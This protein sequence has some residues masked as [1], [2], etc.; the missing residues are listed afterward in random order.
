MLCVPR[1]WAASPCVIERMTVIL[2]A[3]WA[4]FGSVS[5][6]DSPSILVGDR[7]QLA[8]VFD[9]GE[10]LGV[11]RFLV[12]HAAG[13]EDVDDRLGLGRDRRVVLQLGPGL[14]AGRSR[15]G[16][17]RS[18]TA[19]TVRNPRRLNPRRG[20]AICHRSSPATG[21]GGPLSSATYLRTHDTAFGP[22]VDS[23]KPGGMSA[24]LT[25]AALGPALFQ[26][27]RTG[28]GF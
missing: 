2:S 15:P 7:R 13:Q 27:H 22:K 8:A 11:E 4:V 6:N 9:R 5:Q 25:R 20:V 24:G 16:S 19:P 23:L 10:R 18:P 12:G 28:N 21:F 14:A 26:A 3:I 17:G 1:S